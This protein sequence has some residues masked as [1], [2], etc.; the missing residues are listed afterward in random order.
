MANCLQVWFK[1]IFQRKEVHT[2]LQKYPLFK[3]LNSKE[4]QFVY[5]CIHSREFKAGE[6]IFEEG[7]PL[8]V[9][10]FIESGEVELSSSKEPDAKLIVK[11]NEVFGLIDFFSGQKR[12]MTAK[13]ISDTTLLAITESDFKELI[14]RL[15]SLGTK[16]LWS[17]CQLMA[18]TIQDK[19]QVYY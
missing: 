17:C 14:N 19:S 10:Y 15:P 5:N 1:K 13:A 8:E 3:N 4:L 12:R 11:D 16:I 9:I 18:K 6:T 2:E 7:F